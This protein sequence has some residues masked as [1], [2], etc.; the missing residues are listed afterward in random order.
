MYRTQAEQN[1]PMTEEERLR[2]ER[3]RMIM[4]SWAVYRNCLSKILEDNDKNGVHPNPEN[5]R[6]AQEILRKR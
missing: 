5:I 6:L 1:E 4:D 3:K 2:I